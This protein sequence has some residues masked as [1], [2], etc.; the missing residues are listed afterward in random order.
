[1][2]DCSKGGCCMVDCSKGGCCMVD[3][4][5]GGCCMVDCSKA[6]CCMAALL[7][8]ATTGDAACAAAA[9]LL[10]NCHTSCLFVTSS[11]F[12]SEWPLFGTSL[13]SGSSWR[14]S[15]CR[16]FNCS[17]ILTVHKSNFLC[18]M[19]LYCTCIGLLETYSGARRLCFC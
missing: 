10:F 2:V 7:A 6:G 18:V 8:A 11:P 9:A 5:K 15:C 1:M 3:R 14:R 12:P 4:Y 16:T 19:Y 13:S 17:I